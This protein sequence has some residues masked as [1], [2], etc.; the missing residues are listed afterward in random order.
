MK[1]STFFKKIKAYITNP[2]MLFIR[3]SLKKIEK[4][5]KELNDKDYLSM[6]YKIR[7]GKK[8]NLEQPK[9]FNEKMQWL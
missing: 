1:I 6:L 5:K 3:L 4:N 2:R 8:L 9:T 7:I